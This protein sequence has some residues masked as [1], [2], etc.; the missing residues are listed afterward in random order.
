A[1][2]TAGVNPTGNVLSNDTDV[3]LVSNGETKAVQGVAA[4]TPGGVLTSGVGATITGSFGSLVLNTDGGYTYTVDNSNTAVE[5]LRT[6]AQTLTDTF[7]YTMKDT[8][9]ATSS[10]TLTVTIHG[11]NDAPVAVA[12]PA[13]ATEAGG[14]ANQTAGVN[15]T[16]NVLSNDTDVDLVS[17]GETKA[18][19]GVAAGTPSGVLT[20]GVVA[21]LTGSFGSLVLNT[22]GSYTYT[23][24]N[25]NTAVE[26][27]RTSAQ[28]L[29]D[30]FTYTMKDT[31]G[32][33]S[34]TT[35]T[36]TIHGANDAPVAVADPASA[37]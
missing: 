22:D 9:G 25:S 1:N 5:G 6:S 14:I 23:V 32:A 10:T 36:V 15:P 33:T 21:T 30:T 11:A 24:D 17:N 7:T 27:L 13:S 28:T 34:S 12:D 3:D 37:T 29:T 31:S 20:S 16:G 2:Q 35:L 4:G 8:A 18:V 26:G 19:Q